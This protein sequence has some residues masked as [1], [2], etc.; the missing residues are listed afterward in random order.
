[1]TIELKATH[2]IRHGDTSAPKVRAW[3]TWCGK[4]LPVES[5]QTT[6]N[7]AKYTCF[8]CRKAWAVER[9]GSP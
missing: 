4:T 1:M 6:S 3:V 7:T 8:D 5:D 9:G 2:L